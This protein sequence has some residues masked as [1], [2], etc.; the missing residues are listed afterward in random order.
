MRS[1]IR[2]I[3]EAD[4]RV[5]ESGNGA[6]GIRDAREII[7]DLIIS[8][9][10]MPQK[11]GYEVCRELKKNVSTSHIPI[12]LLT[13]RTAEKII[14][15]LETGADDYIT[16]PFHAGILRTKIKNLIAVRHQLQENFKQEMAQK[17]VKIEVSSVDQR[18]IMELRGIVEANYANPEFN[19]EELG[20][21]LAMSG[22]T[23]YRK[24]LALTGYSPTDYLRSYR[25]N[26][27]VQLLEGRFGNITKIA[28]AVGFA[29]SAYF[30]K[31]FKEKFLCS[32]SE[33]PID[34]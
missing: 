6:E 29:S 14:Q 25:L 4:Y 30:S 5:F 10:M 21:T 15:G 7:P 12:I 32:P 23:L 19:V 27:A 13:A 31:C 33:Y 20:K 9:I 34:K 11:D 24:V 16:K 17:P 18:F 26:R 3:L 28:L 8:D 2:G 1:Y 22:A